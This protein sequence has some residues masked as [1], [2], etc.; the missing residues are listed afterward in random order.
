RVPAFAQR[1]L[2]IGVSIAAFRNAARND[3]YVSWADLSGEPGCDDSFSEPADD[4]DSACKTRIWFTRS[5]DGGL[6]WEAARKINDSSA[7]TDQFNQRLAV[8]PETGTLGII[9]YNTGTRTDRK[10]T[11]V[12]F[13]VSTDNG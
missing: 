6:R 10:K 2:L 5:V 12:F 9:Y 8:D 3:V 4:V 11:D 1:A 7:R 13:Q